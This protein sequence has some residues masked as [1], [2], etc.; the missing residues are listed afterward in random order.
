MAKQTKAQLAAKE[1]YNKSKTKTYLIRLNKEL[2]KDVI[3][4]L[5]SQDSKNGYI[6]DLIRMDYLNN[7]SVD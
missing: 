5:E 4:I 3:E 2:D 6:K 1:R 7:N